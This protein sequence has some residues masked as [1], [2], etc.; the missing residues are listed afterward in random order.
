MLPVGFADALP[1]TFSY[2]R[3]NRRTAL[4]PLPEKNVRQCK[5]MID[6]L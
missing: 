3:R 1:T 6:N 5:N 2:T 4:H